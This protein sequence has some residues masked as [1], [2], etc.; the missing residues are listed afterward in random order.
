MEIKVIDVEFIKNLGFEYV[1]YPFLTN[2]GKNYKFAKLREDGEIK[3]IRGKKGKVQGRRLDEGYWV[4]TFVEF[5]QSSKKW[6]I[7]YIGKAEGQGGL[8]GRFSSYMSGDPK[9]DKKNGPQ[10]RAMYQRML[11]WLPQGKQIRIY[12][13][14]VPQSYTTKTYFG[15]EKTFPVQD[16]KWYEYSLLEKFEKI[17]GKLPLLNIQS[18]YNQ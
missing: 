4:Y 18:N 5:N 8:E 16:A 13:W 14:P 3:D 12:A 7:I 9:H 15:L 6:E 10:N 17:N 1:A 2:N 11:E